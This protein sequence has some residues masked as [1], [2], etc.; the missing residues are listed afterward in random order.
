[1]AKIESPRRG[2]PMPPGRKR[3]PDGQYVIAPD[4][5]VIRFGNPLTLENSPE[6]P[7]RVRNAR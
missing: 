4:A 1:M 3:K 6:T 5:A 7:L 2:D